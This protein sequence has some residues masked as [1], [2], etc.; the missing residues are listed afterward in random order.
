M[1]TALRPAWNGLIMALLPQLAIFAGFHMKMLDGSLIVLNGF[2]SIGIFII[3]GVFLVMLLI[4]TRNI[5]SKIEY[6]EDTRM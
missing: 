2:G 6:I 3:F 4:Q 1:K 5:V